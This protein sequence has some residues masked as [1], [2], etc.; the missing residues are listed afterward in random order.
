[1]DN[2]I[3]TKML[4]GEQTTQEKVVVVEKKSGLGMSVL[5]KM[6]PWV[7][8]IGLAVIAIFAVKGLLGTILGHKTEETRTMIENRFGPVA[9]LSTF[10]DSY[11]VLET[12]EDSRT[13]F[14]LKIPFTGNSVVVEGE[15]KIKVGFNLDNVKPVVDGKIIKVDLPA[16]EIQ[17]NYLEAVKFVENNNIF[18]PLSPDETNEKLMYEKNV[19]LKEAIDKG[20]FEKASDN[21]KNIISGLYDD[22]EGYEVVI[23][24]GT[25]VIPEINLNRDDEA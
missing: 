12:I 18:N 1:M 3:E 9:E 15:G 11:T 10:E 22:M 17:D 21:V 4:E 8:I 13:L 19:K 14:G 24:V 25:P 20:I 2:K 6:I 7:A 16:P 5:K 23:N